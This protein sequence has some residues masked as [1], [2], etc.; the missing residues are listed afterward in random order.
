M[1]WHFVGFFFLL[2][3]LGSCSSAKQ[4]EQEEDN[5]LE[6]YQNFHEDSSYQLAHILFPL[7]GQSSQ[8]E[9]QTPDFRWQK[10]DWQIHQLFDED[11]SGFHS[12][13]TRIGDNLIIEN[14][15]HQQGTYG[16]E[17]R[18][19]KLDGQEWFLIYYADLHPI[20]R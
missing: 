20:A 9:D 10:E 16:M 6:F 3:V 8:P 19:S 7:Q 11:Q 12:E 2:G 17:R 13:F 15:I 1:K 14:I 5:F 18:F 4:E